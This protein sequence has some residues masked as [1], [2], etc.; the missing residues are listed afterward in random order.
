MDP[1][2]SIKAR[3]A[4]SVDESAVPVDSVVAGTASEPQDATARIKISANPRNTYFLTMPHLSPASAATL[5]LPGRLPPQYAPPL[6][7]SA[8]PLAWLDRCALCAALTS[9]LPSGLESTSIVSWS[10]LG[11][12]SEPRSGRGGASS[13]AEDFLVHHLDQG[14]GSTAVHG[15]IGAEEW[16]YWTPFEQ[17]ASM[18]T[19]WSQD[20][21]CE[22]ARARGGEAAPRARRRRPCR[23]V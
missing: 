14:D 19:S 1:S 21:H 23:T 7:A 22:P 13:D 17:P 11:T 5:A 12:V 9:C 15:L 4:S 16:G 20:Q 18:P 2:W 8:A 3:S 10:L 6:L